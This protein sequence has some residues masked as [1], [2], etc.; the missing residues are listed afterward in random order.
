MKGICQVAVLVCKAH[1]QGAYAILV[2]KVQVLSSLG[3]S[4]RAGAGV[5]AG[6]Q[7]AH[8]PAAV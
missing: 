6:N 4:L 8:A 1:M 5:V 3:L 7:P 2:C